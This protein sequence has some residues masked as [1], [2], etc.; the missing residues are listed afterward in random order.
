MVYRDLSE[1][2]FEGRNELVEVGRV[3]DQPR[4]FVPVDRA[5]DVHDQRLRIPGGFEYEGGNRRLGGRRVGP[6][7][8]VVVF[9]ARQQRDACGE[10]E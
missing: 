5:F 8:F 6:A 1:P 7:V 4:N 10:K 2:A 9:A 3:G